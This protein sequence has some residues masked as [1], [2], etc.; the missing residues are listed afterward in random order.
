MHSSLS[1]GARGRG[2]LRPND[3]FTVVKPIW[4]RAAPVPR[5]L[6]RRLV[7]L[8]TVTPLARTGYALLLGSAATSALGLV[9]WAVAARLYE[10]EVIGKSSALLSALFLISGTMS[11]G[12]STVLVRYLPIAG[13]ASGRLIVT[14][15]GLSALLSVS[16]ALS[17]ALFRNDWLGSGAATKGT[18]LHA[19]AFAL[20]A[21][22]WSIFSLQDSALTGMR[23]AKWIPAENAAYGVLKLGFLGAL[24]GL[25][26]ASGI[27][28]SWVL[29]L[30]LVIAPINLLIFRRL[31]SVHS[32]FANQQRKIE[33]GELS[34][35]AGGNWL[36]ALFL[37]IATTALPLLIVHRLGAL[38]AAYFYAPWSLMIGLSLIA[39]SLTISMTVEG[40]FDEGQLAANGRRALAHIGLILAP[41]VVVVF[42]AAPLILQIFGNTYS[43]HGSLVLRLLALST[44]PN[45]VVGLALAVVRLR[46]RQ[47][48]VVCMQGAVCVIT[49]AGSWFLL[50][51]YGINGAA[52]AWLSSQL[53]VALAA[54]PLVLRAL[55]QDHP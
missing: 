34:R 30:V 47:S 48:A 17:V 29:P 42:L 7:D 10:P 11:A 26:P 1:G 24:A 8:R 16:V 31:I 14:T 2:V 33:I 22:L 25:S 44:L 9:Y 18:F 53:I 54:T 37:I 38:A 51:R 20:A 50:P 43:I 49:V 23:G 45:V 15:Y 5:I 6:Q 39:T 21:A 4:P 3:K 55:S 46:G 27:V 19:S 12:L 32:S 35:Y 36:G 40:A 41:L 28:L 13:R 52:A